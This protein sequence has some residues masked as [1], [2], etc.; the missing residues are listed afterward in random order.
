[1]VSYSELKQELAAISKLLEGF[2]DELKPKVFELLIS[3][4]L[5]NEAAARL[6]TDTLPGTHRE[7][8]GEVAEP[9]KAQKDV[10]STSKRSASKK[11]GT[12]T[13]RTSGKESY[14]LDRDLNLRGSSNVPSFAAF[15]TEKAP[16]G[17]KQFNAV[18]VYYLKELL[19]LENVT[20]DHVFTCYSEA[21]LR[22]PG[23]FRQSFIDT[24]NKE[25]W[26][27][28]EENGSLAIPHRG[29]VYVKHDL[30]APAKK[31]T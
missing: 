18:A 7:S 17:A 16:K 20:L 13:K 2:S 9:P 23:A 26:I 25:G 10:R 3:E 29:V 8:L 12:T 21:K 22:P 11:P 28:F 19:G 1:M 4:Y 30:P 24:K 15:Y 6:Q 31:S 27:E 14:T 5:G